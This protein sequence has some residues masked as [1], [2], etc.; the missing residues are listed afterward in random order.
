MSYAARCY[1]QLVK[2]SSWPCKHMPKLSVP[3]IQMCQVYAVWPVNCISLHW[4]CSVYVKWCCLLC[5]TNQGASK[6]GAG[7]H[8]ASAS[9]PYTTANGDLICTYQSTGDPV[10]E[11]CLHVLLVLWPLAVEG[12]ASNNFD[13]TRFAYSV[14]L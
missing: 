5:K 2:H 14:V 7:L 13:Y 11:L 10:L 3:M 9:N 8:L 12:V 4:T 1:T 6:Y